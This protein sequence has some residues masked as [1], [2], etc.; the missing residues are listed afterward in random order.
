MF[1]DVRPLAH[2]FRYCVLN[3]RKIPSPL[4]SYAGS[5]VVSRASAARFTPMSNSPSM[6]GAA[7]SKRVNPTCTPT[8]LKRCTSTIRSIGFIHGRSQIVLGKHRAKKPP[9]G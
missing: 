8:S 6:S 4:F 9:S 1:D 3:C 2:S 5:Q 7:D